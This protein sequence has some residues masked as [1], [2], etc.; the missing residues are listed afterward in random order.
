MLSSLVVSHVFTALVVFA[1]IGAAFALLPGFSA[2]YVTVRIR[3]LLALAISV[4]LTPLLADSMP[5][6]PDQ[7]ATLALL[8]LAETLIGAFLATIAR[9][10]VAALQVAGTLASYFTSLTSAVVND[11]VAEQ[12]S[13]TIAGFLSTLGVVLLFVTDL[14]HLMVRALVE[15][16]ALFAPGEPL[17]FGAFAEAI[18]R[19]VA[20]CMLLGLQMAAPLMIISVAMNVGLGLLG[21]LMPQLPVFFFG[22]PLQISAQIWVMMI[23]ISAM[24]MLFLDHFAD[25][26]NIFFAP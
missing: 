13:S 2:A 16:Y 10:M 1:R 5:P 3:L 8:L 9:I 14:H 12:Q 7:P 6:V 22:L 25:T 4:L 21:R 19:S 26:F 24:M 15:S 17:S 20:D 23:T 18:S 11:P